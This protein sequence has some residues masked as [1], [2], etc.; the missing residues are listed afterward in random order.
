MVQNTTYTYVYNLY[1][2]FQ[3]NFTDAIT[4]LTNI[5]CI[6][7]LLYHMQGQLSRMGPGGPWPT[8]SFVVVN[9]K[10]FKSIIT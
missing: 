2:N 7:I 3:T 6:L 5:H 10:V 1:K 4:P 8:Q 9:H